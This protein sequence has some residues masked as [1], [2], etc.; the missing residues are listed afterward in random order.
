MYRNLLSAVALSAV[1]SPFALAQNLPTSWVDK[2]TGHRVIRLTDE[3]GSSGFYFNVNAYTPDGKQMVYNAPD[4]IHALDLATMK[5]RLVVPNPPR[6]ADAARG[7][8]GF[9]ASAYTPSLLAER[10]TPSSSRSSIRQPI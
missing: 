1:L 8:R 3:P 6:P 9:S 7:T 5:T 4:G 2:D 10:R